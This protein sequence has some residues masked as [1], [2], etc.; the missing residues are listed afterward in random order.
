MA[1]GRGRG[2][3]PR[4]PHTHIVTH[5]CC[6]V[7]LIE[8][9]T[10]ATNGI[11]GADRICIDPGDNNG[12]HRQNRTGQGRIGQDTHVPSRAWQACLCL[13]HCQSLSLSLY[14]CVCLP[15]IVMHYLCLRIVSYVSNGA[16]ARSKVCNTFSHAPLA[17][18]LA[19]F[20]LFLLA[21]IL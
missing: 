2:E 15:D 4:P 20:S 7:I 12:Q 18:F 14:V 10:K 5:P 1:E 13:S 19:S 16:K 6:A 9:K 17:T 21:A 8:S 11:D 3:E